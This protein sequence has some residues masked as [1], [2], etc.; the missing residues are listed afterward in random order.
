MTSLK[1]SKRFA[2]S[3]L[4]SL[5]ATVALALPSTALAVSDPNPPSISNVTISAT[6]VTAGSTLHVAYSVDDSDGVRSVTP[7]VEV[8]VENDVGNHGTSS[9]L[10][11]S[12]T[13]DTTTGFDIHTP[14]QATD[15][16]DT[17]PSA[18]A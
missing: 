10:A 16:A 1:F 8:I 17:G 12:S 11:F 7:I 3:L 15:P 2:L 14:P 13:G 4:A 5:S 9:R 6:T 18:S